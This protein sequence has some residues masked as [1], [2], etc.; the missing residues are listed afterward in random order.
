MN[1]HTPLWISMLACLLMAPLSTLAQESTDAARDP[2]APAPQNAD[3]EEMAPG[4]RA[5][6]VIHNAWDVE[7]PLPPLTPGEEISLRQAL[8]AADERNLSLEAARFEV[9]RAEARL[10]Q[11]WGAVLPS[12]QAGLVWSHADKADVIDMGAGFAALFE[13]LG[14][15]P[16]EGGEPTVVQPLDTVRG[17]LSIALPLVNLQSWYQIRTADFAIDYTAL[18]IDQARQQILFGVAQAYTM[19]RLSRMLVTLQEEQVRSAIYHLEVVRRRMEAEAGLRIDVI[20]AETD[21]S[22]SLQELANAH[23][24]LDNARDALGVLT[25]IDGLPMPQAIV[26]EAPES[27]DE[28]HLAEMAVMQN[29]ELVLAQFRTRLAEI[30]LDTAWMQFLPT[31]SAVWQ[32]TYSLTEPSGFGGADRFRWNT[33]LTLTIPIFNYF[34]YGDLDDKRAALLQAEIQTK[35]AERDAAHAV[36]QARRDYLSSLAQVESAR[37][38]AELAHEARTMMIRAFEAGV[39]TS[40]DVSDAQ[41]NVSLAD[42]NLINT[43]LQAQLNLLK[44]RHAL[45]EDLLDLV[46][47]SAQPL[48]L[49]TD[50]PPAP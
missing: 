12:V 1:Q 15:P 50:H 36:R 25:G 16:M 42:I 47:Q 9:T 39:G 40:L 14:L 24:A 3:D 29:R 35:A 43:E 46:Y 41:R 2:E 6:L 4:E 37:R 38:Q 21:L 17:S 13:A 32:G 48:P 18:T 44:L 23:L 33:M 10:K 30:Q 28:N 20:R 27:L 49:R 7:Y 34:R 26:L 11:S 45:G 5:A 8:I 22:R 31:L 19:A